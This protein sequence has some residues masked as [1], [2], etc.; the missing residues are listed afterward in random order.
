V[1]ACF[2]DRTTASES[3]GA[4]SLGKGALGGVEHEAVN[5]SASEWVRR[6]ATSMDA[7]TGIL[8]KPCRPREYM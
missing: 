1:T 6:N 2:K 5:H 4:K 7:T 8:L 3:R